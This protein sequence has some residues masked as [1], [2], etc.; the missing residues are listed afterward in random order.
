[1]SIDARALLVMNASAVRR[2]LLVLE[3]GEPADPAAYVTP[4][5]EWDE[6]D[7]FV[8]PNG[9]LFV[10]VSFEVDVA[11]MQAFD[12]IWCVRTVGSAMR[13]GDD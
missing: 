2:Y 6:G 8:T 11:A 5:D 10:I 4:R 9:Q 7:T 12:G 13:N 3:D 1:L